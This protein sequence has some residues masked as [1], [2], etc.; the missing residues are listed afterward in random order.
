M[1]RRL[2]VLLVLA[3]GIVAACASGNG[4]GGEL[5]GTTWV[6]RSYA[7]GGVL[8]IVP[9][10]LYADA[11]FTGGRVNGFAGCNDYAALVRASGRTLLISQVTSTQKACGDVEMT[12]E[13]TFLTALHDSRF[14]GVRSDVLTIFAAGGEAV[15][16]FDAAPKN[17]L[18]GPWDVDSFA[19]APGSQAVPISG[20]ELTA[21]FS[22][23][24][25]G[26]NS[27]C[28]TYD[29]VYGTN[30]NIVKISRLATTRRACDDDVMTQETAFLAAL[31]SAVQIE[32][33]G[34]ALVLRD[35]NGD[36]AV[37][38]TRPWAR[39]R[40]RSHP[41]RRSR[42]PRSPRRARP[43]S[44]PRA[45]SAKP[46]ATPT[47]TPTPTPEADPDPHPEADA[48]AD[49]GATALHARRPQRAP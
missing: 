15:L 4:A 7:N 40:P 1:A 2:A 35:R 33:R 47:P 48:G 21:V 45:P 49:A 28:N 27:G 36:I 11:R 29:G 19:N 34:E 5:Q 42:R 17:P 46:S 9:D 13:S 16:V 41:S 25:V 32:R 3:L 37:A 18:L 22:V 12:F 10:G 38:M 31:E 30:G 26:G 14:Y 39:R 20:T 8:E 43:R 23:T 6:L 24:N 44:R